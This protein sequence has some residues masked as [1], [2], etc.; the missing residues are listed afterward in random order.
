MEGSMLMPIWG[1]PLRNLALFLF[2][3]CVLLTSSGSAADDHADR[4]ALLALKAIYEEA[5]RENQLALLEP[6]LAPE[7]S[8]VMVTGEAV[9][10]FPAL[11]QY[12]QDIQKLMGEGGH[13]TVTVTEDGPA[14]LAGN[15]AIAS[16]TTEDEVVTGAGKKFRFA[17]QWTA[18]AQKR[19]G[20]WKILRIHASMNPISNEFIEAK[21]T[22]VIMI[23]GGIAAVGGLILGWLAHILWR[24]RRAQRADA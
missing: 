12:W 6:H 10:G 15:L 24:A 17:S 3:L 8:G 16:G 22:T 18:I 21:I 5:M 20:E 13:Y 23:T 19:G 1:Y 4:Q 2:M 11:D 9:K 14:L 7:F